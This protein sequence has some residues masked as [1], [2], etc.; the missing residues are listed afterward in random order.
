MV[1]QPHNSKLTKNSCRI[2]NNRYDF[3]LAT[4]QQQV[5]QQETSAGFI[6]DAIMVL[7]PHNSKLT[8]NSCRIYHNNVLNK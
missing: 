8:K 7:Q 3:G 5:L 6:T 1:S 2:Y 4:T